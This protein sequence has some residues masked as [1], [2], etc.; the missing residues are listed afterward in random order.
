MNAIML[1]DDYSNNQLFFK[2]SDT[3]TENAARAVI[4][5]AS[6][7]CVPNILMSDDPTHLKK[8]T[9]RLVSNFIKVPHHFCLLYYLLSNGAVKRLGIYLR[10]V[11]RSVC[12]ELKL[13]PE[14]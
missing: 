12:S 9:V 14:E 8:D 7:F 5:R 13:R 4:D 1:R 11:L 10:P 2:F 3:S 6:A